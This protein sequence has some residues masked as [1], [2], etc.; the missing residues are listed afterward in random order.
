MF[1]ESWIPIDLDDLVFHTSKIELTY[2]NQSIPSPPKMPPFETANLLSPVSY[3]NYENQN[4][5]VNASGDRV[6]KYARMS[7][8]AS[9]V[10]KLRKLVP[11]EDMHFKFM[12][13]D[14]L[15]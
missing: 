1:V 15:L 7:M 12:N 6:N 8:I 11:R 4:A 13:T 2:M 3:M 9:T 5:T 14:A 10:P